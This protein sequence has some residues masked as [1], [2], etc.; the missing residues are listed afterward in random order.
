MGG[1]W[2]VVL[3][4]VSVCS[5][6]LAVPTNKIP[7]SAARALKLAEG[8]R[9][10]FLRFNASLTAVKGQ[11]SDL[12]ASE[13]AIRQK[14]AGIVAHALRMWQRTRRR[15]H[16]TWFAGDVG[17]EN[18]TSA[19][20]LRPYEPSTA[21]YQALIAKSHKLERHSMMDASAAN[22]ERLEA[23]SELADTTTEPK[24]LRMG[25][26]KQA[27]ALMAQSSSDMN[28]SRKEARMAATL[29][30]QAAQMQQR[31]H[32][33]V[34]EQAQFRLAYNSALTMLHQAQRQAKADLA[35]LR[36]RISRLHATE[37][38]LKREIQMTGQ[39]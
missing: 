26:K 27:I 1:D 30:A 13:S 37:H 22:A 18:A 16:G 11:V 3:A 25:S 4:L 7:L 9:E 15:K 2:I 33:D 5:L 20:R 8:N 28:E 12:R 29:A 31:T 36:R 32:Q 19:K 10:L 35:R 39:S 21:S 14:D 34:A 24:L 38:L 23:S 17:D 6:S